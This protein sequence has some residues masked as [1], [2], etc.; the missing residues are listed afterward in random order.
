MNML[1]GIV[2]TLVILTGVYTLGYSQGKTSVK[3]SDFKSYVEATQKRD[4]LQTQ[5]NNADVSLLEAQRQRDAV[6]NKE[7]VKYVTVYRDRIKDPAVAEC[8]LNSGLLDVYNST[9]AM[10]TTSK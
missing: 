1:T 3:V 5:L 9:I 6:R 2:G 10:P 7:V 4:T 8:V